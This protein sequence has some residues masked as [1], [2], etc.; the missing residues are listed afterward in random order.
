MVYLSK[1]DLMASEEEVIWF[2]EAVTDRL[3]CM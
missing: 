3:M 1:T 2:E